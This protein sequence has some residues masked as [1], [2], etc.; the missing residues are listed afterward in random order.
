MNYEEKEGLITVKLS[1]NDD[2]IQSL[3]DI[4]RERRVDTAIVFS[5]V[6][7]VKKFTISSSTRGEALSYDFTNVHELLSLCGNFSWSSEKADYFYNLYAVVS[8]KNKQTYGGQLVRAVVQ[9]EC[10]VK[11]QN[12]GSKMVSGKI[13]NTGQTVLIS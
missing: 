2:L 7:S 13:K 8:D 9:S 1:V 6:G 3:K 10:E 12:I 5:A 11:L 4:C